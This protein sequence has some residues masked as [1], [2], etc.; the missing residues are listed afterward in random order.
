MSRKTEG[1]EL[2][3]NRAAQEHGLIEAALEKGSAG[4]GNKEGIKLQDNLEE[5]AKKIKK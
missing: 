2:Q 3:Q 4:A 5:Q 1:M